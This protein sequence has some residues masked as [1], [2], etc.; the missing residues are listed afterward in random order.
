MK[1]FFKKG[2]TP[3]AFF[4]IIILTLQAAKQQQSSLKQGKY[5]F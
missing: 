2:F 4:N 1:N 5:R 3:S